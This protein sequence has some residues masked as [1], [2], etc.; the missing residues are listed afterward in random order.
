MNIIVLTIVLLV[1]YTIIRFRK[2]GKVE[3][4]DF[5]STLSHLYTGISIVETMLRFLQ[6]EEVPQYELMKPIV[7]GFLV[8]IF[9]VCQNLFKNLKSD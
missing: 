2:N 7:F 5:M 6:H 8:I 3:L 1:V 4:T 9:T